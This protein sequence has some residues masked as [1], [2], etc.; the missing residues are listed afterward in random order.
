MIH[1]AYTTGT[2]AVACSI[3]S[4]GQPATTDA[5]K[6]TCERCLKKIA[7]QK[8]RLAKDATPSTAEG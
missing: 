1:F 8:A 3:R 6:V 2:N 7:K 5:A 4:Y